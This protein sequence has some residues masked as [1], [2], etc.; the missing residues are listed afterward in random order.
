MALKTCALELTT[1]LP[2][3]FQY[4]CN[5]GIYLTLW[6]IAQV[7]PVHKKQDKSNSA[8]YR[9]ISLLLIISKVMEGVINSAIKQHLLSNNLLSDAQFGFH[10]GHY[11]IGSNMDKTAEFQ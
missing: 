3:L 6:N 1:L 8:N 2:K 9:T 11:S 7:C 10:Q 5:T 4:S